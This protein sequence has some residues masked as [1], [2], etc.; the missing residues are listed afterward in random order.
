MRGTNLGLV[1]PG[2]IGKRPHTTYELTRRAQAQPD[3]MSVVTPARRPP[4]SLNFGLLVGSRPTE[5]PS[6]A[7]V[8]ATP[9]RQSAACRPRPGPSVSRPRPAPRRIARACRPACLRRP[10][11]KIA[12]IARPQRCTRNWCH[13]VIFIS[14]RGPAGHHYCQRSGASGSQR[15]RRLAVLP[16]ELRQPA[17]AIGS[18]PPSRK[19]DHARVD[20]GAVEYPKD[21]P[22]HARAGP[23]LDL[24]R[25]SVPMA[26]ETPN[27]RWLSD[28]AAPSL[29]SCAFAT[30]S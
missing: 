7:P 12:V 4:R 26:P 10:D 9:V 29:T 5:N 13:G 25:D 30:R 28:K 23:A 11:R 16:D 18:L 27:A 22:A 15:R 3:E 1:V 2:R 6:T 17:G 8:P 21:S 14:P 19:S 24:P 20:R